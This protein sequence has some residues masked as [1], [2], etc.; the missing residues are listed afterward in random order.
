[1]GKQHL[2][3]TYSKERVFLFEVA[4]DVEQVDINVLQPR[5]LALPQVDP[6]VY[7]GQRCALDLCPHVPHHNLRGQRELKLIFT[8]DTEQHSDVDRPARV[9]G[10]MNI[11]EIWNICLE[12][13]AYTDAVPSP[14][15]P[16]GCS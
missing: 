13:Y 12:Q 4:V 3:L 2:N 5:I 6:V 15:K 7:D 8:N 14:I 11:D 1:M 10:K 16:G 9:F